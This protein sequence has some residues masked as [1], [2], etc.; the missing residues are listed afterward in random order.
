[1]KLDQAIFLVIFNAVMIAAGAY[2]GANI[3]RLGFWR[4]MWPFIVLYSVGCYLTFV[5]ASSK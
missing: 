1:M 4:S 2:A 3:S 5:I